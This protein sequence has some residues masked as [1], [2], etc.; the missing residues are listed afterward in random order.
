MSWFQTNKQKA[1]L[2][3]EAEQQRIGKILSELRDLSDRLN[4]E[5]FVI[6]LIIEGNYPKF[7]VSVVGDMA[8]TVDGQTINLRKSL[9]DSDWV[10]RSITTSFE[11]VRKTVANVSLTHLGLLGVEGNY[12]NFQ[13]VYS[14]LYLSNGRMMF[15]NYAKEHCEV[16]FN[17]WNESDIVALLNQLTG[18]DK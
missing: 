15:T 10:S 1:I 7:I 17:G 6:R 18:K 14:L 9:A 3:K 4:D 16:T 8:T 11:L 2:R 13:D 5:T 12:V